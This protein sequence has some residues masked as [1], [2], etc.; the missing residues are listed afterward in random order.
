MYEDI[1]KVLISRAEIVHRVKELAKKLDADYRGKSPVMV[2]ILKGAAPFF[3]EL[4]QAMTIKL[5]LDFMALS[6]YGSGTKSS[7]KVTLLKDM[8]VD[9]ENRHVV[10]VEDIVDSGNTLAFLKQLFS[11]R[12]VASIAV[13]TLLDKFERRAVDVR[14][15]YKGFDIGNEFVV[16]YGLDYAE[17][18]RNLPE[19]CVL[20]P[21]CV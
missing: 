5:E 1:E 9:V 18:Y 17:F 7:G 3:V 15:D 16:G 6:S 19:I 10:I 4:T 14:V 20:K 8:D 11:T 12:H 2:C 13:C 21:E